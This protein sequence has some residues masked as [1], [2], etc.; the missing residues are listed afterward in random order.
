M[1]PQDIS[2]T[3]RRDVG[4]PPGWLR[5]LPGLLMLKSYQP[6]WL[7]RDLAA[8]LV[9]TTMLVPVGIAYAEAS[10]VP[11]V[12]G[13]YATII[14]LLAYALLGPSRILVLGPDSALAAPILAVVLQLSGG[15]PGRAVL[16]A[17]MMAVV[18]GAFCIILGLL[19]LGFIT[20]LLSK[21]IRYGYMNGI[22]L[23]VLVSQLPKL[24]A[25]S[26]EDAGPLR[27]LLSLG[28]AMAAGQANW[29][30]FAVGA[31]SLVLILLLKRFER[32]P[33]ILIAVIVATLVVS[34][35]HLDQAG[36]K[37]LGRIPQ[38]LPA[39]VVP[40]LSGVD[41]VEI[42]LGG[43]AVA[44][45]SFAD[46]SVLSRT[47]AARTNTRVDPNQEM[48][49]L[50]VANLAAGFFQGFPISSSAS[51]TP[52]AEA[53]G[54]KTQLTGVVGALAVAALLMFAPNLLQ[55]LP[56]SALAAVVI[57]AAIGLFEV[58]D[59]KR[60]YRIQQWEFWLSMVCFAAVAVFG[61]IPGIF[62]AVV[63]A[64]IEFLWDGWRPHFAVLGR[65]EGLRGY[66]DTKRYPHA[67]RIDGL[68]LFRWDAPLFF[69]NAELFQQRLMEAIEESPTPVRRVVVAAE[70][71]TSVDVTSADMLRELGG[72][73]RERGIALHFAE[74]KDPVRDKLRR[75]ELL[76][77]IG[78]RNFHPTVGS[79][80][81]DYV[82]KSP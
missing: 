13:L 31:G 77:A 58:A 29:Y 55:Y 37:V 5:W 28:Q 32:V 67:A 6:A 51:R 69:A 39:F 19:R 72:I 76:E 61:A 25:I 50:G 68:V 79:A 63:I 65:V 23:A 64:V 81:D 75:F 15:D 4:S 1:E 71:V 47:F 20:E 57:A 82:G 18:A 74:M 46:T 12:Y 17:S 30:S 59:L 3:V 22:A 16:V 62:L 36:V 70:P 42:L 49:G 52:V 66:H 35:L 41:L 24:F 7:P 48:V 53:A 8:G 2:P 56:N 11:G 33:G 45:I 34:V 9:L 44:L 80:V 27:E 21:P 38:G 54:A 43:C 60:I 26:V 14:P 40:W 73:L 78:D 10:G